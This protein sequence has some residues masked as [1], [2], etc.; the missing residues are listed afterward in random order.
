M[1][2][3]PTLFDDLRARNLIQD[4]T[5][6]TALRARLNES[7]ITL[8]CGFDPT[9]KSLHIGNLIPMLT[10]RRFQLAGHKVLSLAGGATG[11]IGDPSGKSAERNILDDAALDKNLAGIKPQLTQFLDFD[12]PNPAELVDNRTWIGSM[13]YLDFLREA[14]KYVTVNQMVAKDSVKARMSGD[15]GIS[16]TEFSYMLVQGYDFYWLHQNMGC[17]MQLGG[18]D[19]WGNI[20]VGADLIRKKSA[21]KA[22]ALSIPLLLRADGAKYGKTAG[23]ETP[24]L[25]PSMFSPYKFY[26]YWISAEDSEV[27]KLLLQLTFLSLDEIETIVAQHNEAPHKRIG[28]KRFAAE[29]TETVHGAFATKGAIEA[30]EVLFGGSVATLQ[31]ASF[32]MLADEIAT[33]K[34][35]RAFLDKDENLVDLLNEA[36]IVS[37][38]GEANRL[39]KQNGVSVNDTKVAAEDSIQKDSLFFDRFC[40]IRK[41]KKNVFLL[42]FSER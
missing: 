18:S 11:M 21:E 9:A 17:E 19:Q 36:Q 20:T 13:S 27:R 30:S 12:G 31:E 35:S 37:S 38:K 15:N 22:Y 41:G 25:D 33:T 4:T 8:Y 32:E 2:I 7:P 26:Q 14:G 5:D 23:G 29:I 6:E 34:V 39:L 28:Q 16:Y 24:W 40:L 3:D 10:L 1:S 42:D